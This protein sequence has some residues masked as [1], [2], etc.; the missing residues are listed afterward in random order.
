VV[1]AVEV[2]N[3]RQVM[4]NL[5]VETAHTFFVGDG[6]WLVHNCPAAAGGPTNPF[7]LKNVTP[8]NNLSLKVDEA[9]DAAIEFLGPG[10]KD[11][12]N[13]RFISADGTRQVRMSDR[14]ILGLDNAAG[15]KHMNFETLVP[16]PQKPGKNMVKDNYHI[17][18]IGK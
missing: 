14:D 9:L 10:Y 11:L 5:S 4:Y 6:Q 13:G 17:V 2:K 16:N 8:T 15:V 7:A 3:D 12:G 1:K 18:L